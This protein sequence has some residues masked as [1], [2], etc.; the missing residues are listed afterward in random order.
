MRDIRDNALLRRLGYRAEA[1]VYNGEADHPHGRHYVSAADD[2][3]PLFAYAV[4]KGGTPRLVWF[5]GALG[6]FTRKGHSFPAFLVGRVLRWQN[7]RPLANG[8]S[9]SWVDLP[10]IRKH[11]PELLDQ[12][13]GAAL[14]NLHDALRLLEG[15][16]ALQAKKRAERAARRKAR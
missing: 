14:F 13:S 16:D 4:T 11:A 1:T 5:D 7:G 10:H 2:D 9:L 12:Q 3:D 15:Y 8:P 6:T